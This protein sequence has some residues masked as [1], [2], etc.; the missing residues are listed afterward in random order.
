[1]FVKKIKIHSYI[2]VC[3]CVCARARARCVC[4]CVGVCSPQVNKGPFSLAA[5]KILTMREAEKKPPPP[6]LQLP[7]LDLP[8]P[9]ARPCDSGA[10]RVGFMWYVCVGVGMRVGVGLGVDVDVGVCVVYVCVCMCV[11]V[12]LCLYD[13]EKEGSHTFV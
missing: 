10:L 3:V 8:S 4:G 1:M 5:L 9:P 13:C 12:C 2:P 7:P 11:C 6:H